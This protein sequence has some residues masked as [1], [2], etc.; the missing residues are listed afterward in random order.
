MVGKSKS[1]YGLGKDT[2]KAKKWSGYKA[3][4]TLPKMSTLKSGKK[5]KIGLR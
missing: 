5:N 4:H 1:N 3:G 2:Y